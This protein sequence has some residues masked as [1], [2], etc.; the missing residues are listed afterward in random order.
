MEPIIAV[1]RLA[2]DFA[3]QIVEP[4]KELTDRTVG[5]QE[6]NVRLLQTLFEGAI[7][8]AQRQTEA[9]LA[10][11]QE[12]FEQAEEQRETLQRLTGKAAEAYYWE[13]A[14]SP[15]GSFGVAVMARGEAAEEPK[16]ETSA[17]SFPIPGYARLTSAQVIEKLDGLSVAQLKRIRAYEMEHKNRKAILASLERRI[18]E[19]R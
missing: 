2:Q 5:W 19:A 4:Y 15:V 16:P 14:F 6:R 7:R 17:A 1:N 12:L 13:L 11:A 8:G 3:G 10:L 18:Q 9:N